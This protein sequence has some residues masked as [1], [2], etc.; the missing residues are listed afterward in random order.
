MQKSA[1][2]FVQFVAVM[3]G[4]G[5]TLFGY[6]ID[7]ENVEIGECVEFKFEDKKIRRKIKG[8]ALVNNRENFEKGLNSIALFIQNKDKEESKIISNS[9]LKNTECEIYKEEN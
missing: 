2:F 6:T 4:E 5:L 7:N 3:K 8:I 1:V 9:Y